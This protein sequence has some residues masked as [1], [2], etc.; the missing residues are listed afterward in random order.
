MTSTPAASPAR[1]TPPWLFLFLDLPFGAAVG[2]A[3]IAMPF[4]LRQGGLPLDQVGAISAAVFAPHAFKILWIPVLDI[5]SFKR[6]WYLAMT[7][8][9][10][11]LLVAASLVPD[12]LRN[13]G[14]YTTLIMLAQATATTGHAAN[15]ALMAITT[16][17]E[18]KG[19]AGGFS[20]A[21]NVGGTGLL[22]ALAL[23][24]SE[25]VSPRAGG[26]A[27]ALV[28]L[29]SAS[30]ALRIV[31]P[32]WVD[33]A[34]AR[35][36]SV[37]RALGLHLWE[38]LK[39]LGRTVRSRAGFTGL[40][41]CLAP[42]GCGALTNLFAGMAP[43]F[44]AS[45]RVVELVNGLGG[46]ISAAAGSLVGGY[47]ADRMS[48]RLA[49]ALAGGITALSA[50]AMLLAPLTP[51]TYAWGT[52]AYSFANGI[53]FATWAGMVLELIGHTAATTTK[54]ALFNA[55]SNLA[56]SY[57]TW[58]DGWAASAAF[59]PA[60]LRGSHGSLAMDVVLTFAGIA[61]LLV[62]L[63][64]VRRRGAPATAAEPS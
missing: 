6:T 40:V 17:L 59:F 49:Y 21:S 63:A 16:R 4:W 34:V 35:A 30:L 38:M 39:D 3:M 44:G 51:A 29:A 55:A 27:L 52:L 19:K 14:L 37:S 45:A 41:I 36:G 13:L 23:W 64:V 56:I 60:G 31:E 26:I 1:P 62:M 10:A 22:G 24:V 5:G 57:V 53:A 43:D 12:P 9:T 18:D 2:Y 58:L 25:H 48:R 61:V 46:G 54:Y 20:M 50:I 11:A 7:T 47:V 28:V 8:A 32:R 15:N 42:V 33:A